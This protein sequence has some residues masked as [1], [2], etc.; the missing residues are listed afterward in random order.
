MLPN[1]YPHLLAH[2]RPVHLIPVGPLPL[3]PFPA[4]ASASD[5]PITEHSSRALPPVPIAKVMALEVGSGLI[6]AATISPL[7]TV[8]DKSII[9]NASGRQTLMEGVKE[10]LKQF[11]TRP[12]A[13]CKNRAFL[14][15]WYGVPPPSL[16][17]LLLLSLAAACACTSLSSTRR[18]V[19]SGTVSSWS[20]PPTQ[21][22]LSLKLNLNL[23]SV[24]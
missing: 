4:R 22:V 14:L 10:G 11:V 5:S 8:I 19:F 9:V 17:L 23:T 7:I 20:H 6:A 24:V 1:P 12:F 16:L 3:P 2:V 21:P 18:G 13:F 15:I